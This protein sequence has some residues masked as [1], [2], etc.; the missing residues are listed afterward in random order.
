MA[1]PNRRRSCRQPIN[2]PAKVRCLQSGRYMAGK[3]QNISSSGALLEVYLPSL[4]VT[5][6]RLG[7]GIAWDNQQTVL[8]SDQMLPA[9]VVRSLGLNGMQHVAVQFDQPIEIDAVA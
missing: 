6:Q 4:M 7:I 3:T 8:G 1:Q 5:G 2:R 9:T